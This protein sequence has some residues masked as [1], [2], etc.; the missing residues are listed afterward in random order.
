MS[1]S[2]GARRNVCWRYGG[3][4]R[5]G[6][7]QTQ[8]S[9]VK[10]PCSGNGSCSTS[11]SNMFTHFRLTLTVERLIIAGGPARRR[12]PMVIWRIGDAGL[13]TLL[14][15]SR[16][17]SRRS[18]M[19]ETPICGFF[20]LPRSLRRCAH[21]T[22][23]VYGAACPSRRAANS[24]A[25]VDPVRRSS[26]ARAPLSLTRRGSRTISCPARMRRV[27][28][29]SLHLVGELPQWRPV[30]SRTFALWWRNCPQKR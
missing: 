20:P 16:G 2:S 17:L 26:S 25:R 12:R 28:R 7:G 22:R 9:P 4:A 29:C 5:D 8:S 10:P 15:R 11:R 6:M 21:R 3:A 18:A 23:S 24:V 30:C 1:G 13:P 14:Q 19:T 27:L